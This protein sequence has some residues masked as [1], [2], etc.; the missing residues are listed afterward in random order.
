M[1]ISELIKILLNFIVYV[2]FPENLCGL[3]CVYA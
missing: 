2:I 1:D 3:P